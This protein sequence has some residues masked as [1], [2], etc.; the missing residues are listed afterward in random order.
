MTHH[1][2]IPAEALPSLPQLLKATSLAVAVAGLLLATVVLPAE[3]G[4]D[5]TGIGKRLGLTVLHASEPEPA[6]V[7]P[8]PTGL[9]DDLSLASVTPLTAVWKSATPFRSD[10]QTL[11]LKPDEG[12]EI[13][14]RM[15]AGERFV[16]NWTTDGGAVSFDMHG[17][18]LHGAANEF[19]SYWKA[20][21][22][23]EGYGA[24]QAPFDGNHGWYWHNAGDKPVTITVQTSG[25]YEKL[26]RP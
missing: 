3:Y 13:K 5:P 20:R 8:E 11:T 26:Y 25:Y 17:D 22:K 9:D 2:P 6:P 4:I 16:F 14:A 19:S 15:K 1:S 21:N 24:F 12:V 7:E 18:K 23:T 10:A